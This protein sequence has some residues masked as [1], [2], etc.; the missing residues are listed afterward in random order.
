[1]ATTPGLISLG[2]V[3]ATSSDTAVKL[4]AE[5]VSVEGGAG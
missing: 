4:D 1:M 3:Y 2:M 5:Q